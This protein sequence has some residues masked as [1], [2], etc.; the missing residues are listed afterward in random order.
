[1]TDDSLFLIEEPN[2]GS[3]HVAMRE[4]MITTRQLVEDLQDI[5]PTVTLQL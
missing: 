4:G 2:I 3:I 5:S 1:M